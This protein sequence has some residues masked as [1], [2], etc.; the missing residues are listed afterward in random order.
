[1]NTNLEEDD[2]PREDKDEDFMKS[3]WVMGLLEKFVLTFPVIVTVLVITGFGAIAYF[4]F[5]IPI[6]TVFNEVIIMIAIVVAF[7]TIYV[8]G[9]KKNIDEIIKKNI[10]SE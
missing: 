6:S 10:D 1:M 9:N 7:Y 4:F 3:S 2:L 5:N 8:I